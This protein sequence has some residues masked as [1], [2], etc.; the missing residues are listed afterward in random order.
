MTLERKP[1][2]AKTCKA[3]RNSFQPA[4]P[5]QKACGPLCAL[6]LAKA[7]RAKATK[8]QEAKDRKD[9]RER[10]EKAKTRG[11]WQRE[12]QAAV[13]AFVR[14][15]DRDLPCI[16][17]GRHHQGK[18]DAGHYRSVG[19]APHLR[20][21][22][23]RNIAKQCSVCNTYLSGNLIEYRKQLI[24]RIGLEA[25]EAL[26]SDQAPRHYS[27]DDLKEIKRT[28]AAKRRELEKA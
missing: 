17:C 20:F 11:A 6:T 24:A 16:S 25:V 15:R 2:K 7:A 3:C 9:L 19:S 22:V 21:D 8:A 13:N 14:A 18:Y 1:L 5:M 10:K 12:A 28:F 26:E 23:E 4:R 27:V